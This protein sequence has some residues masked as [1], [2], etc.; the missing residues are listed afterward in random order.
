MQELFYDTHLLKID[1]YM[2]QNNILETCQ[3]INHKKSNGY[4]FYSES[5]IIWCWD[6]VTSLHVTKLEDVIL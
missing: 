5:W 2:I 4:F 1:L 3:Y 6:Y